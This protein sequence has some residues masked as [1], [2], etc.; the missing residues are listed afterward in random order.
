VKTPETNSKAVTIRRIGYY[1]VGLAI[2]FV[3]MATVQ[4]GRN[5]QMEQQEK[6]DAAAQSA[7]VEAIE[8]QKPPAPKLTKSAEAEAKRPK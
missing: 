7:E 3:I 1:S 2:G 6:A 5:S 4:M 8:K